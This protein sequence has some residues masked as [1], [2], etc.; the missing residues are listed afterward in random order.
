VLVS[1]T[2][3]FLAESIDDRIFVGHAARIVWVSNACSVLGR[4][5]R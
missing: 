3:N 4:R 2:C 1:N 5:H